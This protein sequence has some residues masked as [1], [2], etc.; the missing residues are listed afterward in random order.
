[1]TDNA[2]THAAGSVTCHGCENNVNDAPSRDLAFGRDL[3]CSTCHADG[4]RACG[5]CGACLAVA[6]RYG[7]VRQRRWDKFFCSSTCRVE[8]KRE[9]EREALER[10]AW[11]AEHPEDAARE[12]EEYEAWVAEFRRLAVI[13]GRRTERQE[14]E[15]RLRRTAEACAHVRYEKSGERGAWISCDV[16]F[17]SG[18]VI[19]R[20]HNQGLQSTIL[21]FCERHACGQSG[22][23]HNTDAPEGHYY[24]A[25]SCPD[26]Q[27]GSLRWSGVKLCAYCPRPVRV[28]RDADPARFV[29]DWLTSDEARERR[30]YLASV[31]P[32]DRV[33]AVRD[34]PGGR[35]I[36]TWCS[37]NC[38]RAAFAIEARSRRLSGRGDRERR[39]SVCQRPFT[40]KRSDAQTCSN[41]CRQRAYR[42]RARQ[43][44][45]DA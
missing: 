18:D 22:G 14:R 35:V 44:T 6:D 10:A 9:R 17:G 16:R 33:E 37:Q 24:P 3:H 45:A 40:P 2:S 7:R 21:P 4:H 19:Y 8:A 39:C 25:C 31:P 29:R 1:M 36:R 28:H 13:G 12:R 41:T 20:R 26:D 34:W 27:R 43:E 11:E 15:E 42:E 32:D 5:V 38:K 30:E 23:Y